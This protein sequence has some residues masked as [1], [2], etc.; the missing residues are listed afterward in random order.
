MKA[1]EETMKR[2]AQKM[3][4]ALIAKLQENILNRIPQFSQ[5]DAK[6]AASGSL[7]EAYKKDLKKH[8][9][10]SKSELLTSSLQGIPLP[11]LVPLTPASMDEFAK[12]RE[13]S[14][15]ARVDLME[16]RG[17]NENLMRALQRA[18]YSENIRKQISHI[19]ANGDINGLG[20]SSLKPEEKALMMKVQ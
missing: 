9:D 12:T 5:I 11:D 18:L 14:K 15:K 20:E 4:Q 3:N 8:L 16:L 19:A 10:H 17:R 6:L 13:Q 2:T 7:T 1:A